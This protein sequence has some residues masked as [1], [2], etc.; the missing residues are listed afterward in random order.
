MFTL[1]IK[2]YSS[3]RKISFESDLN[4]E[5]L[6]ACLDPAKLFSVSVLAIILKSIQT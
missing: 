2:T 4:N 3:V 5:L 1:G 6:L